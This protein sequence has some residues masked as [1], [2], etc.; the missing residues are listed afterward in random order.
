LKDSRALQH[1]FLSE[2]LLILWH[3]LPAVE[4]LQTVWEVKH[5]DDGFEIHS[6]AINNGLGNLNKYSSCFNEKPSY[7]IALLLH[8]YY[9]PNYIEWLGVV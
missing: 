2:T 8:P 6:D 1:H 5:N 4:E 9:K 3:V 7:V